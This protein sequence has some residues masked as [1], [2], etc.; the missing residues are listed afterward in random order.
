[1]LYDEKGLFDYIDGAAPM[2]IQRHFRKLGAAE[3]VSADG[4]E[5]TCDIYDM[6]APENATAIF[7]AEKSASA[8]P[9]AGWP[10]AVTG[11]MSF[12]FRSGR[13]YA[14]LTAFDAKAD[15]ALPALAAALRTK[16]K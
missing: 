3:M 5:L 16:M 11:K 1:M 10:E 9:V 6:T 13:Y 7:D 12:V 14:K 15:A 2:Y 8:K 4:G